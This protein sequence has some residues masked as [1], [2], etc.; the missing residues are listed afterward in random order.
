[1]NIPEENLPPSNMTEAEQKELEEKARKIWKIFGRNTHA[2]RILHQVY[3]LPRAIKIDYPKP[4]QKKPEEMESTVKTVKP[5]PQKT[6]ISY[7]PAKTV[8]EKKVHKVDLIPK[9]KNYEEIRKEIDEFYSVPVIPPNKDVDRGK[10]ID[11][12]Q[13]KF[14]NSRGILPKKAELP[15]ISAEDEDFDEEQEKEIKERALKKINK[16]KLPFLAKENKWELDEKKEEK[17]DEKKELMELYDKILEEME[18]RQAFLENIT[19]LDEP[20]LKEKIK[21][22]IIERVAEL[23]KI[24]EMLRDIRKN[25]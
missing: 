7:P 2:G 4:K 9:R 6:K 11:K 19:N 20:D 14:K 17:I 8:E 16:K 21:K 3:Q 12:L 23:Q 24:T 5:C 1:M 18:E 22:E 25:N 13:K 15:K 10:E